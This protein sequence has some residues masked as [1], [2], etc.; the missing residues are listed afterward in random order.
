MVSLKSLGKTDE[1]LWNILKIYSR[2]LVLIH[3]IRLT[4]VGGSQDLNKFMAV[5]T[6]MAV[7]HREDPHHG[8]NRKVSE[9]GRRQGMG[10]RD[11]RPVVGHE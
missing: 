1:G 10:L 9:V 4:L 8:R 6:L 3:L 5:I 2:C 7:N 11:K